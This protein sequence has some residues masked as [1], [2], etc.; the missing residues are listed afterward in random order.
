VTVTFAPAVN[1]PANNNVQQKV[2]NALKHCIKPDVANGH[3]L[4][5]IFVSSARRQASNTSNH[6]VGRAV[7]ISRINGV[8]LDP[9]FNQDASVKAIAT[10]IQKAF[11]TFADRRENFGPAVMKKLGTTIPNTPGN[12]Q[13][14]AQHKNHIHFSVNP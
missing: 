1:N 4:T 11:E 8:R 6:N 10:A 12:R 7:D 5:K 9:G 13:L 14:I 2:V 3:T